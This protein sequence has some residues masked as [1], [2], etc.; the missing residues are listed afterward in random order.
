VCA[1]SEYRSITTPLNPNIITRL[2][3][4]RILIV[5][6]Y[7]STTSTSHC[8]HSLSLELV[9]CVKPEYRSITTPL[10][11]CIITRLY[12]QRILIVE[13]YYSTTSISH[14]THSLSLELVGVCVKPEYRSIT[15]PLNPSIITRL[16]TQ[17]I[18]IVEYYYSTTSISH[19]THSLSLELV[20]VCVKP[21]YR[22]ITTPLNPSIIFRLYTQRILIVEYYY[23]ITSTRLYTQRF[24]VQKYC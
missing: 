13:Y 8:T 11:P 23:S 6:Y 18:L 17:R 4:Q 15:T 21:E 19:Y 22:S 3:T 14:Y 5:E 9:G 16:Y 1:K 12:T 24:L 10:N 7:Y 20:G 2:Y